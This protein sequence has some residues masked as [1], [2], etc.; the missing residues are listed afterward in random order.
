[1]SNIREV[2][3][4]SGVSVA[5][6]SRALKD[7]QMVSPRTRERVLKAVE[8]AGYRPNLLARNFSSGKSF[9]VMVLVPNIANPFFSRVIRG[10]E[11]AAQD[12]GYS[13]LLGD[14]KGDSTN[15]QFY[16]GMALTNQADGV[17]QLGS[18]Y[19]FA[20]KDANLAASVP[21]VNACERI[22]ED[23]RYPVVELDNHGAAQEVARHLMEMGHRR[24]GVIT[25]PSQSPIVRDR[26]SGFYD[27]LKKR[28][29]GL[30]PEM[31]VHGEFT[32]TSGQEGAETLL[33]TPRRPTAIFCMNDEMAIGAVHQVKRMGLRVPEDVSVTGFDNIEFS[34]FTDPPLTTINQ[35]AEELG[36][37]A[38]ETL[39]LIIDGKPL[40]SSRT[41]LPFELVERESTASCR[42]N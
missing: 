15:E 3:R 4:R 34:Q 12:Q 22:V 41:I 1:M 38:M 6:V 16:A 32:M 17:I 5:T 27:A 30:D 11:K 21:L 7:P 26:L 42:D 14:T 2:A 28:G 9:A 39:R 19:P 40:K 33:S 8:E 29:L 37:Y 10:I 24:I 31:V 20:E 25:G 18:R 13:V 35:P 36:R 23:D